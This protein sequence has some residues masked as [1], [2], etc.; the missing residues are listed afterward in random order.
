M[1]RHFSNSCLSF[2][3]LGGLDDDMSNRIARQPLVLGPGTEVFMDGQPVQPVI[4]SATMAKA[5]S[6]SLLDLNAYN[7]DAEDEPDEVRSPLVQGGAGSAFQAT[8]ILQSLNADATRNRERTK[9]N[10]NVVVVL[11]AHSFIGSHVVCCLLEAGYVVRAAVRDKASMGMRALYAMVPDAPQNLTL[12]SLD[13]LTPATYDDVIRGANYV[14]N[15]LISSLVNPVAV[16]QSV[17]NMFD[18]IRR[19]GK[20]VKRV[21]LTCSAISVSHPSDSDVTGGYDETHWNTKSTKDKE[22]LQYAKIE[23]E[24]EAVRLAKL[25]NVELVTLLPTL[26]VGPARCNEISESVRTIQDI[27]VGNKWFPFAPKMYWN[28]VDV[29][30]VARAHVAAMENVR[31]ANQRYLIGNRATKFS[32][33]GRVIK[34]RYPHLTPPIYDAPNML[35]LLIAPITNPRVSLRYL[36]RTLGNVRTFNCTKMRHDLGIQLTPLDRT[37]EDIVEDLIIAGVIA[38]SDHAAAKAGSSSSSLLGTKQMLAI[39]SSLVLI[40]GV[41]AWRRVC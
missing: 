13:E 40:G 20:S 3:D 10:H 33:I 21:V 38:H 12:Y 18:S 30:D 28:F 8:T 14:I 24:K 37:V 26:V 1:L 22:P 31:A 6:G 41:V 15:T 23:A 32:E 36:W 17:Q 16:V 2:D 35:T 25:V 11:G 19:C 5:F 39:A 29:R 7:P 27:A 9:H 34:T 4:S